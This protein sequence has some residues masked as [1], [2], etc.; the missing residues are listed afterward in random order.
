[1][2]PSRRDLIAAALSSTALAFARGDNAGAQ[3]AMSM[4]DH[5]MHN[6]PKPERPKVPR[7]PAILCRTAGTLGL[8]AA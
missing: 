1:M 4:H 7:L 8:D 2:S 6:H 5:A 3:P